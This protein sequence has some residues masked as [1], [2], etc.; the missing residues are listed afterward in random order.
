M[1]DEPG[2]ALVWR[3]LLG[4]RAGPGRRGEGRVEIPGE[5]CCRLASRGDGPPQW[6]APLA[7]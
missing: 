1:E 5:D 6:A 4:Q 7:R 3:E 2:P